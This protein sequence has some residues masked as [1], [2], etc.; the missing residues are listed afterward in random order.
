[1][2]KMIEIAVGLTK[3]GALASE[4]KTGRGKST[5]PPRNNNAGV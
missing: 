4:V 3:N 5:A 1:M 2:R